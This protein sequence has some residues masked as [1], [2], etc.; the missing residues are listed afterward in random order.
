MNVE[1]YEIED[2]STE[3]STMANDATAME[4]ID[5]LG[6][7]GQ[8]KLLNRD[9][10]TRVPYRVA[11][12]EELAVFRAHNTETCALEDYSFD[13]IPVR[14]LQVAEHA[15]SLDYFKRFE[16]H[17]PKVGRV[18]D[19]VLYGVWEGCLPG[20]SWSSTIYYILARWGKSL[21]PYPVLRDEAIE[22]LRA[23]KEASA[24]KAQREIASLLEDLKTSKDVE[25]LS[26]NQGFYV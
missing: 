17:Y 15:R 1:T 7:N 26:Q 14:V 18:D 25:S 3:A 6:L 19:P 20:R 10:V 21:K 11:E 9:T 2:N 22:L 24:R 12:A 23:K 8:K 13:S 16:V 4:L 5:K